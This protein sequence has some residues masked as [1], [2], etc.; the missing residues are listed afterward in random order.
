MQPNLPPPKKAIAEVLFYLITQP[1]IKEQ[2]FK[3]N[4][5]RSI[6]SDL[7][8]YYGLT[9]RFKDKNGTTKYD[10]KTVYR[11]TTCG[12]RRFQKL[13]VFTLK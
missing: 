6:L 13:P 1:E 8:N 2:N 9:I 11:A 3:I 4:S 7:R 5:F 12:S 10:R